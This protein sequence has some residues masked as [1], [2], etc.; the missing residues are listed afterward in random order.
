MNVTFTIEEIVKAVKGRLLQGDR[1]VVIQG[2]SINSKT[3]QPGELFIAIQGERLDG[4]CFI[5][6]AVANGASAVILSKRNFLKKDIPVVCVRD[7]T[8]ALGEVAALHRGRF[9]I[10]VIAVTGSTGKTTTKEMIAFILEGKHN[11]LKNVKTENNQFGVPLTILRLNASHDVAV[12]ELGTNQRGDIAWLSY[13]AKPTIAVFTNV[14]ASHLQGLKSPAGVFREKFQMVKNMPIAGQVIYNA[15]DRYLEAIARK[16]LLQER[17][18]YGILRAADNQA[19][20]I[21]LKNNRS[22]R[23]KFQKKEFSLKTPA[24]HNVYNALAALSCG[25]LLGMSNPVLQKRLA[26]FPFCDGRQQIQKAGRVWLIDDTYNANPVS[27]RSALR[28]LD[29][30]KIKGRKILICA[31]M[32]ELG[33]QTKALHESIGRA[34]AESGIG[35]VF[36]IGNYARHITRVLKKA[37]RDVETFHCLTTEELHQRLKDVCQPEDAILVKGSRLMRME[38]TVHFLKQQFEKECN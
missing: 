4:H 18:S 27:F 7:T 37:R 12:L 25:R 31:D 19:S 6:E 29:T 35:L 21:L 28:T 23:F 22:T 24:A 30:L 36:S 17:I 9:Q 38:R 2:V 10:P 13:I 20:D 14:G 3:I 5:A 15:D 8:R 16:D 1:A 11:V 26:G 33:P 32:L 34:A